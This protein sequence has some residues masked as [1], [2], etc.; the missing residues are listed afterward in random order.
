MGKDQT[1]IVFDADSRRNFLLA[2]RH[3]REIRKNKAIKRNQERLKEERK[4]RQRQRREQ[5]EEFAR[6]L[7]EKQ[8]KLGIK[9][10]D[11]IS[12]RYQYSIPTVEVEATK[13]EEPEKE[14]PHVEE[15]KKEEK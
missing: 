9:P 12:Q 3:A 10:M 7:S 4:E 8:R 2:N 14:E 15:E 6:E 1:K 5:D 13:P 11:I